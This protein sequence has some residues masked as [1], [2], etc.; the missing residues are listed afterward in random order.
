MQPYLNKLDK[1]K[2]AKVKEHFPAVLPMAAMAAVSAASND[3][4]NDND[5]NN[6]NDTGGKAKAKK[7]PAKKPVSSGKSEEDEK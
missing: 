3:D 7:A 2:L 1:I 5:N 6:N 4:D